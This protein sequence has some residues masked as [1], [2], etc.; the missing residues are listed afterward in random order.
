[1]DT[2]EAG[3]GSSASSDSTAQPSTHSQAPQQV[4]TIKH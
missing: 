2:S 4:R 1:M 3:M